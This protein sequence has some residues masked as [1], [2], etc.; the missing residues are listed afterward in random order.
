MSEAM[1]E[2]R[3]PFCRGDEIG[4]HSGLKRLSARPET[5]GAEPFKFGETPDARIEATPS[6]ASR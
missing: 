2:S 1:V 3:P 5:V 6:Q 4:K